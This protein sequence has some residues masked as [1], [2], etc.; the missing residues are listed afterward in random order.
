MTHK[1]LEE[2]II[3]LFK[4]RGLDVEKIGVKSRSEEKGFIWSIHA[5]PDLNKNNDHSIK[6]DKNAEHGIDPGS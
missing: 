1:T 2:E 5:K 4:K 3:Q 6:G